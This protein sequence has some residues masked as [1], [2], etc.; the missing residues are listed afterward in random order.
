[1][2][3][4]QVRYRLEGKALPPRPIR[5]AVPGWG[6]SADLKME[7]GSYPQPWH[8]PLFVNGSTHGVELLYPFDTACQIIN[9]NGNLRIVWDPA[10][11]PGDGVDPRAFTPS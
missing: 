5:I 6:G 3:R 10:G 2:A 7:T 11:T 8:C 9:D 1:M 4:L